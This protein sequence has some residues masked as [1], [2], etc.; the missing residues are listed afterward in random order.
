MA[1]ETYSLVTHLPT[2]WRPTINGFRPAATHPSRRLRFL[3]A[4]ASWLHPL[5]LFAD[6]RRS[7]HQI[8]FS[9]KHPPSY[10]RHGRASAAAEYY[11]A[12]QR[13]CRWGAHTAYYW[14]ECGNHRQLA[15][16]RRSYVGLFSRIP[17]RLLHQCFIVSMSCRVLVLSYEGGLYYLI[18][19][20]DHNSTC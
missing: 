15:L 7:P 2:W 4:Y 1:V 9:P 3:R 5:A 10:E 8:P 20:W 18:A 17:S 12:A 16:N 19:Y 11:Y 6:F 14:I 13:L